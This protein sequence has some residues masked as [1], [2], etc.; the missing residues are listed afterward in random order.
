MHTLQAN[1]AVD[2]GSAF[3]LSLILILFSSFSI[4][5]ASISCSINYRKI[6]A[7][8]KKQHICIGWSDAWVKL[9]SWYS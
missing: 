5:V 9:S 1:D 8:W 2:P 6:L 7:V 3:S 4:F